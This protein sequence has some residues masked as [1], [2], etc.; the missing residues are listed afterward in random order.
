MVAPLQQAS[1]QLAC[2]GPI[3]TPGVTPCS[4]LIPCK[5]CTISSA[6]R[7]AGKWVWGRTTAL[8]NLDYWALISNGIGGIGRPGG[9]TDGQG[10]FTPS[11]YYPSVLGRNAFFNRQFHSLYAWRSIGNANYHAMQV[12]LRKRM[13]QG[14]QFDFNYTFSKSIDIS[15]DANGLTLTTA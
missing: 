7:R 10:V 3:N 15:S 8:A 11:Q 2:S 5:Q 9:T 1:I 13:S 14:I 12:N 4:R 6:A